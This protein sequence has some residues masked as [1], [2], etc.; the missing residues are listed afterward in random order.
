MTQTTVLSDVPA[1]EINYQDSDWLSW[2]DNPSEQAVAWIEAD[3][4][5]RKLAGE[6]LRER[7]SGVPFYAERAARTKEI[8][9]SEAPYWESLLSGTHKF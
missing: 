4:Q 7:L 8:E 1:P 2:L 6:Q 9:G 3:Q 5:K